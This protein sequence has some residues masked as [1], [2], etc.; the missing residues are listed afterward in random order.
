MSAAGQHRPAPLDFGRIKAAALSSADAVLGRWL[1]EGRCEGAEYV[2][3]NPTRA[4]SRPGSFSINRHTGAWADFATDDKGGDLVSL[5]AYLDGCGQGEAG[6]RLAAFLGMYPESGVTGV[7]GVTAGA[8]PATAR[9]AAAGGASH[10]TEPSGVT[11]VTAPQSDDFAP[12]LPVPE[13]APQPP[14]RHPKWGA[15]SAR[16]DYRDAAGRLLFVVCRFDPPDG[17]KQILPLTYGANGDRQPAWR[18]KG[19]PVPRPLY[20]L[21]RLAARPEAP[22]IVTEGEKAADAAARLLPEFVAVTSPNGAQSPDKADWSALGGRK[23]LL[24]PDADEAGAKYAAAVTRALREGEAASVSE[25]RLDALR[26]SPARDAATGAAVLQRWI[27]A[28]ALPAGWDAADAEAGGWTADHLR[29]ALG[30]P[31][32]WM[33]P[34][35]EHAA[36]MAEM[37]AAG[38]LGS[39]AGEAEAFRPHF[40]LV[41]ERGGERAPGVYWHGA[42][43]DGEPLAPVWVCSPFAV[44]A[45]TRDAGGGN[46]GRLIEFTDRDGTAH[47]WAMPMELLAG[48]GADLRRELLRMGLVITSNR[49]ARVRL[50]DYIAQ[51]SPGRRARC[52]SRTGWHAGVYVFPH[53]TLGGTAERVIYQAESLRGTHFG[54]AGTLDQWREHVAA[55]CVGNSRLLFACST[56]FA[57]LLIGPAGEESGGLHLRGGSSTGKSTALRAAAS[58]FGGR[59][60]VE[61]WRATD[62]ALEGTAA[63]HT[64]ALLILDELGEV[65]PR[66]AG[67]VAYMLGNG[68]GKGRAGRTGAAR[69][70]TTWRLLFLS[71]GEVGLEELMRQAG[72]KLRPGQEMR[73]ADIAADP[74]AGYGVFDTLHGRADGAA[75]S[76]EITA[77]CARYHGTAAPAF[78]EALRLDL[79]ALPACLAE[80]RDRFLAEV[81]PADASGQAHR[82]AGRFAL[83]AAAGELATAYGITGWPEGAAEAGAATCFRAWLDGRG[84]AGNLEEPRMLAQVRAF[85]EAHGEARFSPWEGDPHDRPTIN[86]AGFRRT[87]PEGVE[88]YVLPEAFRA[89]VCAGFDAKAV[90]RLLVAKGMLRPDKDGKAARSERLPGIGRCSRCYVV[91]PLLWGVEA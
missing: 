56:A 61:T 1:P 15:P 17:R 77:S 36:A 81:L 57:A 24:W 3:R 34:A 16:W 49:A 18:W 45:E 2:A 65:E 21:D 48:D 50:E 89:E 10:R 42:D 52:V 82:V 9:V 39:E 4:D 30:D 51:A 43:K 27:E 47:V 74:G 54:E 83:I 41:A 20:G 11:G 32:N 78:V 86:R 71:S 91:T 80:F 60:Y 58:V 63:G 35:E 68:T 25:L 8:K 14:A 6:R 28:E 13:R 12:L 23:V 5:V 40:E 87:T 75:L 66:I 69:A 44:T 26:A 72:K 22:V 67:D 84:G 85:F 88:F 73:M 53:R 62:N 29:L 79:A 90:A 33:R 31:A 19:L 64:D 59:E 76:R 37:R 55:L 38:L 70:R 7:T 46:W